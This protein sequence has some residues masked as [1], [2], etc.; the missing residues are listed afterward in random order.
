MVECIYARG[1]SSVKTEDLAID[2]CSKR[3]AVEEIGEV[4]PYVRIAVLS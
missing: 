1:E 2:Q 4:F 3:E